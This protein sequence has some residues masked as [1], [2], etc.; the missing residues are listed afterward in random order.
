MTILRFVPGVIFKR[1]NPIV[2]GVDVINGNLNIGT[3]LFI[4]NI[5]LQQV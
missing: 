5:E 4:E 1:K 2:I 3:T